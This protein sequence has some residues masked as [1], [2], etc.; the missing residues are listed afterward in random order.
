[1]SYTSIFQSIV[2]EQRWVSTINK[3]LSK[4]IAIDIAPPPTCIFRVPKTL[5]DEKAEAYIPS[6]IGLG[7]FHHLRP[8]M[9]RMMRY[10]IAAAIRILTQ[11][12]QD[13]N[14]QQIVVDRLK[15]IEPHIR[16]CYEEYLDIDDESLSS[17]LAI[18]GLYLLARIGYDQNTTNHV[19]SSDHLAASTS[20]DNA[21]KGIEIKDD[22]ITADQEEIEIKPAE[23]HIESTVINTISW[24]SVAKI[25]E[26]VMKTPRDI[27]MLENQIPLI[28]LKEIVKV[29]HVNQRT[30]RQPK[31]LDELLQAYCEQHSPLQLLP[32]V[33]FRDDT[34]PA[35]L[36]DYMYHLVVCNIKPKHDSRDQ[37]S[38][39]PRQEPSKFE[40]FMTFLNNMV[41]TISIACSEHLPKP[42]L[43]MK[44]LFLFAVP[45]IKKQNE[46]GNATSNVVE[47]I[48]I[49]SVSQLNSVAKVMFR[50]TPGGGIRDIKYDEEKLYFYLPAITLKVNSEI[51]IRNLTAYE[52]AITPPNTILELTEY[53][54]LLCGLID[55]S[56]DVEILRKEGIILGDLSDD[57]TVK[58]FNGIR[59]HDSHSNDRS[60]LRKAIFKVRKRFHGRPVV[61]AYLFMKKTAILW[62]K[63]IVTISTVVVVLLVIY[64]QV[65]SVYKCNPHIFGRSLQRPMIS[66]LYGSM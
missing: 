12:Q 57:S 18:D 55:T 4:Q 38:H 46:G 65:C 51:I 64:Q 5:V 20:Q 23:D 35:H 31:S 27:M 19:A 16:A 8:E 49:P 25:P 47:E 66:K 41:Q 1:M 14:V 13:H 61:K 28:V 29:I 58:L 34:G 37:Y 54:D 60:E 44:N 48:Q 17:M 10:K 15:D 39:R 24:S 36:L 43:L 22:K 3:T 21:A 6:V 30:D 2:S 63:A 50:L 40:G 9:H 45:I 7:P 42:F 11:D 26:E 52:Q 33:R 59:K 53:I 32:N 56:V 62:W